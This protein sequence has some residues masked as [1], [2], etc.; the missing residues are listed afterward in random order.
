MPHCM[1]LARETKEQHADQAIPLVD[2]NPVC[3]ASACCGHWLEAEQPQH[4]E[5]MPAR[6]EVSCRAELRSH[7]RR[8]NKHQWCWPNQAP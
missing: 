5:A 8:L 1:I 7:A 2:E 3:H 6:E 4:G